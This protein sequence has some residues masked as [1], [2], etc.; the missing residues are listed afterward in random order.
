MSKTLEELFEEFKKV[1]D[2]ERFPMPEVFYT[3]FNVKKPQ[4]ATVMET[5]VYQP[6]PYQS[7][8][9]HGKVEERG[10]LEGGVRVIE[11]LMELPVE[12]KRTN[13][14]TGELEDYPVVENPPPMDWSDKEKV[15]TFLRNL[16]KK[17]DGDTKTDSDQNSWNPPT[18]RTKIE[19][20][21]E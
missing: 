4:P 13:E 5:V 10:P 21:P 6:P 2:W 19:I 8:N 15:N 20:L 16:I 17:N 9:E 14:E 12:V 7:L 11:N 1:P 3:H 18:E